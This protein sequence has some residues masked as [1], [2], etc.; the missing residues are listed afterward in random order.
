MNYLFPILI[1]VSIVCSIFTGRVAETTSAAF[2]G[3]ENAVKAIVAMSGIFCFWTGILKI[4]EKSGLSKVISRLIKPILR[5]VFPRLDPNGTA[6]SAITMNVLANL[7]GMGNAATPAGIE[8][9][10][11]LDALNG[12]SPYPSREM[13]YFVVMNTASIQLI[14]TT[15]MALRGSVGSKNPA[16]VMVPIWITSTVALLTAMLFMKI[17]DNW[18]AKR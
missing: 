3:A 9:M 12:H 2:L 11:K 1:L 8:A 13:C 4:S 10:E 17:S 7:M 18:R 16:A 15:I 6:F 5:R 14:P